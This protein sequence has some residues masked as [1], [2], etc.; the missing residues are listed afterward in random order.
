MCIKKIGGMIHF[1]LMCVA[2]ILE[3][4]MLGFDSIIKTTLQS[5]YCNIYG[6]PYIFHTQPRR[7]PV[8]FPAV[9][10]CLYQRHVKCQCEQHLGRESSCKTS[11]QSLGFFFLEEMDAVCSRPKRKMDFQVV[12]KGPYYEHS[13]R[14]LH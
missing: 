12:V 14:Q 9:R 4:S 3:C 8:V 6:I 10:M 7:H 11:N 1:P 5:K 13:F 2:F